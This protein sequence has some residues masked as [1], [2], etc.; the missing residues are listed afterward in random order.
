MA[1]LSIFGVMTNIQILLHTLLRGKKVGTDGFGNK[2]YRGKARRGQARERRWVIYPKDAQAS[3]VP[4]EWHGWLHHQTD[5]LPEGVSPYAKS[6]QKPH[7]PNQSGTV[8]AYLPP[9]K[10]N[11][12][13]DAAT[14]D[15][16]AWQPPQ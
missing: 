6:W 7:L 1:K 3:N 11:G 2:Y 13:R 12:K 10:K 8:N 15:Y 14:A 9:G 16:V 5:R 4:A